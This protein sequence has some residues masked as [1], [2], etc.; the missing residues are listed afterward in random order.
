MPI[1]LRTLGRIPSPA[2][3]PKKKR[4]NKKLEKNFRSLRKFAATRI[5]INI[6]N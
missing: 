2:P 5:S 3:P 1:I 4:G 6:I